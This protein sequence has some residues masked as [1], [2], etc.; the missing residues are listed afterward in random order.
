ML[1]LE[2]AINK[3]LDKTIEDTT[4]LNS[5]T[6]LGDAE[7]RGLVD[8]VNVT[9]FLTNVVTRN[10][11]QVITGNVD[12]L[13]GI[14]TQELTVKN[15]N[16]FNLDNLFSNAARLSK[17]QVSEQLLKIFTPTHILLIKILWFSKPPWRSKPQEE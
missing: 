3:R 4:R 1:F 14:S 17:D 6:I 9:D 11:K 10:S 13:S 8:N 12:F 16:D 5:V 2:E 15:V 7:F